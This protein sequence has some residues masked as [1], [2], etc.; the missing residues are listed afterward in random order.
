[1]SQH[2]SP[3]RYPGGKQR[4]LPFILQVIQ[5]NNL[6]G[7]EY[8]EGSST[9]IYTNSDPDGYVELETYG[10]L[11]TMKV[12]DKIE[13]TNLYTLSKRTEKDPDSEARKILH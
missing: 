13:R 3:L 8:A 10:P 5:E 12:G 1:M 2:K 11:T 6:D 7:A 4:L 9:V